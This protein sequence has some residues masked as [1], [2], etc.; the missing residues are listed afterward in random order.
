[1]SGIPREHSSSGVSSFPAQASQP[2]SAITHTHAYRCSHAGK[3]IKRTSVAT[4]RPSVNCATLTNS[5]LQKHK[6]EL[7]R[8]PPPAQSVAVEHRRGLAGG[9][10]ALRVQAALPGPG[11]VRDTAGEGS[12]GTLRGKE[13]GTKHLQAR[14][15]GDL[16]LLT[17][18]PP[19]W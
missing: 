5:A 16:F 11:G 4:Q 17:T 3:A 8:L 12:V 14:R 1:M 13:A 7:A 19:V 10:G 9:S 6:R 18:S 15:A 2:G